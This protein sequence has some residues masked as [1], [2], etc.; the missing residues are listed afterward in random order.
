MQIVPTL[1][2]KDPQHFTLHEPA[3]SGKVVQDQ[4]Q[5]HSDCLHDLTV[6]HTAASPYS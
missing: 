2:C 4:Q 1:G 6:R 3:D 5:M